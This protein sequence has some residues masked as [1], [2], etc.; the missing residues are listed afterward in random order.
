M[1]YGTD[2]NLRIRTSL[3]NRDPDPAPAIFVSELQDGQTATKSFFFE[4]FL[5]ITI[6]SHIY[7]ISQR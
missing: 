3:T 4:V 1:E 6:W 5:L 2:S 7:L